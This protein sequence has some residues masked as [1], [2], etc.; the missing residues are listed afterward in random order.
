MLHIVL[1]TCFEIQPSFE[2][3]I[4]HYSPSYFLSCCL[5]TQGRLLI[6][7]SLTHCGIQLSLR[8]AYH[9][10]MGYIRLTKFNFC[11]M[12]MGQVFLIC[13]QISGLKQICSLI[14]IFHLHHQQQSYPNYCERLRHFIQN[15]FKFTIPFFPQ[16]T[17][18]WILD[19]D[20]A[21]PHATHKRI[22]SFAVSDRNILLTRIGYR[23]NYIQ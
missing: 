21:F 8:I 16:P 1:H 15:S 11:H 19:I 20:Q 17:L 13:R 2:C 9:H 7:T 3:V 10:L 14:H 22:T 18:S 5:S 6:S 12:R 4:S 23:A